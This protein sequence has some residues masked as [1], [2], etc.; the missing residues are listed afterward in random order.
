MND[1][2]SIIENYLKD[3]NLSNN[4]N[5]IMIELYKNPRI[6]GSQLKEFVGISETSIDNNIKKLKNLGYIVRVGAK[7]IGYWSIVGI[8][9]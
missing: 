6:T 9:K 2:I 1:D 3:K 7:K 4:M 5:K 8:D